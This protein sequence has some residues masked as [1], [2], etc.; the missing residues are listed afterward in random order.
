MSQDGFG[1]GSVQLLG[2]SPTLP[3][4]L[5]LWI[6]SLWWPFLSRNG[7]CPWFSLSLETGLFEARY[8]V[9]FISA[10]H[11]SFDISFLWR[12]S[13]TLSIF[14]GT[15]R[16]TMFVQHGPT[17]GCSRLAQEKG[18]PQVGPMNAFQLHHLMLLTDSEVGPNPICISER[19]HTRVLLIGSGV[20]PNPNR[21]NE[22]LTH[23]SI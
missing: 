13:P 16:I 11:S 3:G 18:L 17:P 7:V 12:W 20:G 10:S 6:L 9:L 19:H 14:I 8:L 1:A 4:Y 2:T 5:V 23:G 22:C 15:A 21:A